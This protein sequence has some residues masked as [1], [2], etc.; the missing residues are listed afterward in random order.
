[1]FQKQNSLI[2]YIEVDLQVYA[3]LLWAAYQETQNR[4]G[5]SRLYQVKKNIF[6]KTL[7]VTD[8][9][10][11]ASEK[12]WIVNMNE[13]YL[14]TFIKEGVKKMELFGKINDFISL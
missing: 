10:F 13:L 6:C 12:V 1:M 9:Y 14:Y 7:A 3:K 4:G 11:F 5:H 8:F 2:G